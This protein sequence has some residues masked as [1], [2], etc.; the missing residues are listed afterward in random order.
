MGTYITPAGL[1]RKTLQE[2]RLELEQALKQAFGPSFETSVDS[3]NGQLISQLALALDSN[4]T[5]AQEVFSSRDPAQATGVALDWAAALSTIARKGALACEV[6]AM[7]YT[8]QATA[9]IP[10]GSSAM[11]PRGNLEFNLD[12]AVTIDCTACD[13]LLIIDDGSQKNTEY[14]FHFTFGDVTLNNATSQ[15]NLER[16]AIAVSGAGGSAELTPRGLRVFRSDGSSV[17]ITSPLPDDFDVWAGVEG[18]F[19]AASTGAQTCEVGELTGIPDAVSGWVAVYNYLTGVPGTDIE[20]DEA[21]RIRRAAVVRTIKARGTDPAIAAHLVA[22]VTGVITAVVRSNRTMTTDQA[23]G[24]PPKSFESL[25]VGGSDQ[26]VAQCIHDNQPSGIQSYG[27]T[28]V[29]IVDG[30]GDEQVIAFS[31]PQAKYLW[32]RVTYGLYDEELAPTDNEIN[33]ALL[34]WAEN[35]YSMGK[36]VIPDRIKGG[37]YEGTTGIGPSTILVAVTD[38]A[39]GTPSYGSAVIPMG[40]AAYATLAAA[41]ITLVRTT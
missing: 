10:A 39:E 38:T 40:P 14:V 29:T 23:T 22:D 6:R 32:V 3:P 12:A 2:I 35:E 34:N 11:R 20:S 33:A 9:S 25:V 26:E 41:R 27:N 16:L 17:G 21:L 8:D 28:E 15:T 1:K 7:L 4:W 30:N 36:D 31:R 18:D 13:E 37:L 24:R 19:T 5:L